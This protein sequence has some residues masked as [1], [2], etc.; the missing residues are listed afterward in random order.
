MEKHRPLP[1]SSSGMLHS[2]EKIKGRHSAAAE[3]L[4]YKILGFRD[5]IQASDI[6]GQDSYQFEID[7]REG[8]TS[9]SFIFP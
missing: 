1:V 9:F 5:Q 7:R 6:V 3:C 2:L 8:G 4:E